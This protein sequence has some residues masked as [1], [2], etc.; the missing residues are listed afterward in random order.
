MR[1]CSG[2]AGIPG[3]PV[4]PW[5]QLGLSPALRATPG[6]HPRPA[7]AGGDLEKEKGGGRTGRASRGRV[8]TTASK[9]IFPVSQ[10]QHCLMRVLCGVRPFSPLCLSPGT[11]S[12]TMLSQFNQL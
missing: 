4:P 7:R 11:L 1:G 2:T 5:A 8:L 12:L 3:C 9:F 10:Q 6:W